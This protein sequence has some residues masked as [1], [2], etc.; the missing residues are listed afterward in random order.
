MCQSVTGPLKN[1][2]GRQ[3]NDATDWITKDD[4]SKFR[5]GEELEHHFYELLAQGI[6]CIPFGECDNFCP[7]E[8]CK[9]HPIPDDAP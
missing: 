2:S 5:N 8:G 6:E 7:K 3:W 4:G 1:W 9:G